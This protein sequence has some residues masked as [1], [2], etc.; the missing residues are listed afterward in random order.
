MGPDTKP[1]EQG[2][3]ANFLQ[4]DFD[5]SLV[6]GGPTFQL[7]RRT[8]LEGD[9]FQL[10]Y[11]RLIVITLLAWLP[12]LLLAS[13]TFATGGAGR[14]S[15]FHDVE[16]HVRFLIALPILIAAELIVHARLRPIARRLI[17][18]RIILPE[19]LPHLHRAVESATRLRNS[20]PLELGLLAAVYIL[21]C[22]SGIVV[23]ALRLPR[24]TPCLEAAGI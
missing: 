7:L 4:E 20:V 8:H 19:D 24:G 14:F 1:A 23:S 13:L 11:R 22:C 5:F 2:T 17:E 18:R 16:V 3:P 6:L 12:L 10:L 15:F 9:D 21:G